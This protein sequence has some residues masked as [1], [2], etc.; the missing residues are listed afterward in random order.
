MSVVVSVQDV[1]PCR[2]QLTVEVP[3]PAVEAETERVVAEYG[4]RVR[5]PGF[6]KGKVPRHLILKR[7][8]QD[9][10]SEVVE[11]LLP[12]YWKQAEA[13]SAIDPLLPPE[14]ERVDDLVP[15]AP[16]TFVASVETRPQIELGNT[17]DFNLP[18]PPVDPGEMEVEDA[19][20]DL[21]RQLADWAPVDRPAARE[22]LVTA[23]IVEVLAEGEPEPQGG[24]PQPQTVEVEVGDKRVWEELSLAVQGLRA[25]QETTFTRRPPEPGEPAEDRERRFRV[26]VT[27]V[28]ERELPELDDE[29]AQRVQ[30]GFETA[31]QLREAIVDRLRRAKVQQRREQRETAVLDQLRDRHPMELPQG[32]LR[33][34]VENL[35]RDWAE[36]L[37]RRGV[38]VE[39]AGIDWNDTA[40]R[41][42]PLAEKRVKAR[43]LLD[44]IADAESVAVDE[45]EFEATLA[46]LARSQGMTTPALRRSL[47]ENGRLGNLRAQL[48]REKALRRLLGEDGAEADGG[49]AETNPN[50]SEPGA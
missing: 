12:R 48:R 22:D 24:P 43:L 41:M 13:E 23:E 5:V 32:V 39:H 25:G 46:A 15:G 37:A 8:Q 26:R 50:L 29:L 2:K 33:Q 9:I 35:V 20:D 30:A 11:R 36:T 28:K 47:D 1:G 40:E 10:E 49:R 21:R 44:A 16:L 7:F 17:R 4:R 45:K 19:I 42:Q 18:D 31:A 34:E 14:V 38:D 3:A 27:A 6:R